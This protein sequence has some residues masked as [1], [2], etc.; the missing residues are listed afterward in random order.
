MRI[1]DQKLYEAARLRGYLHCFRLVLGVQKL[2]EAVITSL[3]FYN[4]FEIGLMKRVRYLVEV[5]GVRYFAEVF[6][7]RHLMTLGSLSSDVF[8]RRTPTG[9]KPFSL[10]ISLDAT[11]FL[12]PS[13]LILIETICPKICSKSWLKSA[14]RPLPVDVRRSKT[15]LLKLPIVHRSRTESI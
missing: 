7:R 10:L 9:S 2:Y 12:L 8:E 6:A 1:F 5:L 13:V 11:V 4:P 14:K 3:S 15:S